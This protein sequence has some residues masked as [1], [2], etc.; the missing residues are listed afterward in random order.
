MYIYMYIYILRLLIVLSTECYASQHMPDHQLLH[1]TLL[2]HLLA[3]TYFCQTPLPR[4]S[5]TFWSSDLACEVPDVAPF[6][7][8]M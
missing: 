3:Y 2:Y 4:I 5:Y 7:F 6:Y 1:S 8:F